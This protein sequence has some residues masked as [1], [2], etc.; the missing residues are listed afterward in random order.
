MDFRQ[1]YWSSSDVQEV[2]DWI[3]DANDES[4]LN[5][6]VLTEP[7]LGDPVGIRRTSWGLLKNGY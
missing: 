7:L 6:L 5:L 1:N 3:W 4:G 2:Q